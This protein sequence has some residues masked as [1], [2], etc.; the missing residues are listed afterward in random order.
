MGRSLPRAALSR[1]SGPGWPPP[2][3]AGESGR[4]EGR[5]S[6]TPAWALGCLEQR[7]LRR[8]PGEGGLVPGTPVP[9]PGRGLVPRFLLSHS[10][11]GKHTRDLPERRH[12][13]SSLRGFRKMRPMP[14]FWE[15]RD[16]VSG[17]DAG[18]CSLHSSACCERLREK[19]PVGMVW[20]TL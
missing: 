11:V 17:R 9:S 5:T 1:G 3:A 8:I 6:P 14:A 20:G 7:T 18:E 15:R 2:E 12:T 19:T 10:E 16:R 4:R 13:R